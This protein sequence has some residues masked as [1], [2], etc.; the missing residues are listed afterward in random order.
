MSTFTV[1]ATLAH[2]EH[3]ERSVEIDLLVDTGA[4]YTLL[5]P[6]VIARLRLETPIERRVML[7]SGQ[8]GVPTR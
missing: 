2:P 8:R 4:T 1:A 3:R 6:D 7:A 5:P